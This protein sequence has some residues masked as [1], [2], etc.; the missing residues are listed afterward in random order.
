MNDSDRTAMSL[1]PHCVAQRQAS[2]L[3]HVLVHNEA[4]GATFSSFLCSFRNL[5]RRCCH[6]RVAAQI[7]RTG[8]GRLSRFK[9]ISRKDL[10]APGNVCLDKSACGRRVAHKSRAYIGAQGFVSRGRGGASLPPP[11]PPPQPH[12][13]FPQPLWRQAAAKPA[14]SS[15]RRRPS[16]GWWGFWWHGRVAMRISPDMFLCLG[17]FGRLR[18]ILQLI[19]CVQ[20]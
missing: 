5:N 7:R 18:F 17:V 20:E 16:A 6:A 1:Q 19:G 15:L 2:H 3:T 10:D 13:P 12:A 4:V 11:L 8:G 9:Q 14:S